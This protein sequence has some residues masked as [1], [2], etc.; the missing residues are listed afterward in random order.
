M[1][2][3]KFSILDDVFQDN[4]KTFIQTDIKNDIYKAINS[5]Y[6]D[7]KMIKTNNVNNFSVYKSKV[8]TFISSGARYIVAIVE[9]DD[10][11]IG[12][13]K[14]LEDLNWVSF[15]TRFT[16]SEKEVKNLP[17]KKYTIT[18]NSL[19]NDKI[20]KW[21]EISDKTIYK[22]ENL[23]LKIEVIHMKKDD[24]FAEKGTVIAAMELFQTILILE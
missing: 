22:C 5:I 8:E 18:K 23:P 1:I 9:I 20:S 4:T 24:T 12:T 21:A 19:L 10:D 13:L 16:S 7:F 11:P 15:Q 14:P 17:I 2:K 6:K 3:Q